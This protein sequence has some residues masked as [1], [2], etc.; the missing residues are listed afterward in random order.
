[1]S[2][3]I[4]LKGHEGCSVNG[5][6]SETS[7]KCKVIGS[8][9]QE[10]DSMIDIYPIFKERNVRQISFL[11]DWRYRVNYGWDI[12]YDTSVTMSEEYYFYLDSGDPAFGHW[13][14]ESSHYL[15][16]YKKLK[17][18]MPSLKLLSFLDRKFKRS[19]YT[20]F[21]IQ[22]SDIKTSIEVKNN[23]IF[24]PKSSSL[25]DHSGID[26]Y[27]NHIKAYYSYL[28]SNSPSSNKDISVLYLPRG[29]LENSAGGDRTISIQNDLVR[30]VE[31]IP[32]SLV[33]Y[34]DNTNS[35]TDQINI[36]RRA[37]I[38]ILDYGSNMM[39]NGFFAENSHI[40]VLNNLYDH[41][42]L[43]N[44]K[45][46]M[47]LFDSIDRGNKYYYID[48]YIQPPHIIQIIYSLLNRSTYIQPHEHKVKCW[49]KECAYCPMYT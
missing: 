9:N 14:F 8:N 24:F 40:I 25:G 10:P 18:T 30:C 2:T 13:T 47:L 28:I 17:Q 43:K 12:E 7:Y 48:L 49:K 23:I 31:G 27:M 45:P 35:I 5:C 29:T 4:Q 36:V 21:E 6:K 19:F 1:M 15:L 22:D 44:L 39:V 16:M 34:S 46:A 26:L 37:S 32:N 3:N 41:L 20:S 42:H 33:Y 11:D 38:I